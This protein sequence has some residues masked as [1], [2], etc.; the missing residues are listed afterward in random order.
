MP[1][2]SAL[3]R[4]RQ[5]DQEF[6]AALGY[7][8]RPCVKAKPNKSDLSTKSGLQIESSSWVGGILQ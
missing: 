7:V 5:G 3:R 4:L 1:V 8:V 2:I 6:Q